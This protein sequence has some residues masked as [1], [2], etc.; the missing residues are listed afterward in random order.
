ML[1]IPKLKVLLL[2]IKQSKSGVTAKRYG[3]CALKSKFPALL[4]LGGE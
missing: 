3:G 1:E 4:R 2:G